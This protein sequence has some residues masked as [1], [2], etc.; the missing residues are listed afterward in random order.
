MIS[1][2]QNSKTLEV[3]SNNYNDN[4]QFFLYFTVNILVPSYGV[5]R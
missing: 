4:K 3:L 2:A 1:S 5:G